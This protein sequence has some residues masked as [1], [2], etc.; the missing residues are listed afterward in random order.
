MPP[1]PAIK[2]WLSSA[3]SKLSAAGID[4]ARLDAEIILAFVLN[5]NRIYLHTHPEQIIYATQYKLAN[6]KLSLR[7]KNI[8]IAYITGCK[9]F[10]GRDFLVTKNTLIPRPESETIIDN[11][12]KI[13]GQNDQLNLADIGTGSGC[14]GIT[15]KLEMPNLNVTISDISPNALKIASKNA[16]ILSADVK[17][18]KSNLLTKF[19]EKLDIIIANLPYVDK[20]WERSPE[21]AYEPKSAL[22]AGDKGKSIIKDLITQSHDMLNSRGYLIIE[23]DP[24]Q[25]QSLIEF[26][27]K[28]NFELINKDNFIL[29]FRLM[30]K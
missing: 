26:A 25:H 3:T 23:S 20:T 19:N 15:A 28:F 27:K 21:T 8:P 12:K 29:T 14:L 4:T 22:F 10:Y 24:V 2:D 7:L 17:I 9:E 18:K 6:R 30:S 16:D 5:S 13:V 11:L 1:T